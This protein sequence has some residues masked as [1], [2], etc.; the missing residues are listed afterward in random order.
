MP[1][2]SQ[3]VLNP[4]GHDVFVFAGDSLTS[5]TWK[6]YD[7]YETAVKARYTALFGA[8]GSAVPGTYVAGSLQ[9]GAMV[10]NARAG[11]VPHFINSGVS[12]NQASDI[13]DNYVTRIGNYGPTILVL[14]VGINEI[15]LGTAIGTFN[16]KYQ[17][18]ITKA[19]AQNPNLKIVCCTLWVHFEDWPSGANADDTTVEAFCTSIR[20]M[21]ASNNCVL[22]D[23]RADIFTA[24]EPA[25]N[26][27]HATNNIWSDGFGLHPLAPARTAMSSG[28]LAR[29][30][31]P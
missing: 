31:M 8:N 15:V 26:P 13:D 20:S 14:F 18:I 23:I 25:A 30:S 4:L 10:Y 3:L 17:S 2:V 7:E 27:G 24:L 5:P 22:Y 29:T 1:L 21:A 16:T 11:A 6:W 19:R 9:N 12:G 28:F